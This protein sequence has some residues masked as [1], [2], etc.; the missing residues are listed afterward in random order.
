MATEADVRRRG[1]GAA[2][3]ESLVSHA[4]TNGATRIWCNA[5][6]P[7]RSFYERGGFT[8]ISDRFEIEEIGPHYVMELIPRP[9]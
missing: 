5:R 6:T 7:A 1:A 2:V 9:A 3:L 8:V 4:V